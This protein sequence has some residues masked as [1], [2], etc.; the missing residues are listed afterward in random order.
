[1]DERLYIKGMK[2]TER[3]KHKLEFYQHIKFRLSVWKIKVSSGKPGTRVELRFPQTHPYTII[4][5]P[6]D[7]TQR[8]THTVNC[9]C[10]MK[11]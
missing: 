10:R 3:W 11:T 5:N 7:Q 9:C 2:I 4:K 8:E 1:M 6:T